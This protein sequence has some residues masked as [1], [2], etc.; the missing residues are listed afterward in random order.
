MHIANTPLRKVKAG[1]PPIRPMHPKSVE[2]D[3]DLPLTT[4]VLGNV[5]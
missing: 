1:W 5:W 2:S 3:C 4:A